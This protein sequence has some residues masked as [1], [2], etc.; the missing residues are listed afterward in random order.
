M[1]P[2]TDRSP[3]A[4]ASDPEAAP[5]TPP[6]RP[7]RGFLLIALG[8]LIAGL[9]VAVYTVVYRPD[10]VMLVHMDELEE[11]WFRTQIADFARKRHIR[12]TTRAY[13]DGDELERLLRAASLERKS[14]VL[15]AMVPQSMLTSLAEEDLVQPL[16][17]LETRV[18]IRAFLAAMTPQA[19]GHAMARGRPHYVP[20]TIATPLLFYSKRHVADAIAHWSEARARIDGALQK[21]NG[22]GLPAGYR[23]ED[24]PADWDT[25]DIAVLAAFWASRPHDGM[26]VPRVAH[27]AVGDAALQDLASRACAHG[28][29]SEELLE[30]DGVALRDALAW[31][32][33]FLREGWYHPSMTKEQWQPRNLLS[34]AA[35]GQLFLG[36]LD[37]SDLFRLHGTG[38]Q[39]LEGFL[40]EPTDLGVSRVPRGVSLDLERGTVARAGDSHAALTG[41]W[42]G[43]PRAA[44]DADLAFELVKHLSER[45]FQVAWAR[46]FGRMPARRDLLAE[47]DILFEP[48]WQFAIARAAKKQALDFGR[49]LPHAARWRRN[50]A[51]LVTA[52][53]QGCVERHLTGALD[54]AMVLRRA[55]PGTGV[56]GADSAATEASARP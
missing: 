18:R 42:W 30:L 34:A 29:R 14:R 38:A 49:V 20:A 48:P 12:L 33:V 19:S 39:G 31:E 41:T 52:W 15:V 11:G 4:G 7:S 45:E 55:M 56:A 8:L 36:W 3:A 16:D 22:V 50:S 5:P 25:Y 43:I 35:Q 32:S 10:Y 54:L 26:T 53:R 17:G 27:A 51:A 6:G 28:A 37:S 1:T 44:P 23:L 13:R 46:T 40:R 47:I 21:E 24:D 2:K 9:G